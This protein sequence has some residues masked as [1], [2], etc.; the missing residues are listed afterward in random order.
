VSVRVE[1]VGAPGG[2]ADRVPDAPPG[3]ATAMP[4]LGAALRFRL[5]P[6]MLILIAASVL[7]VSGYVVNA[8]DRA[9]APELSKRALLIGSI[10]RAELQRTLDLGGRLD[11]IGGLERYLSDTLSKF[12]EVDAIVI[13]DIQGATVAAARRQSDAPVDLPVGAFATQAFVDR[14][15]QVMPILDGNRLVG[16]IEVDTSPTFVRTRLREVFLD[17]MV[18]ALATA[19]IGV[20]LTLLLVA[21]S[22]A[23]PLQ[24]VVYLLQAQR[25]GDFSHR[26]RRAGIGAL[27]RAAD[28]LNDHAEDLAERWSALSEPSRARLAKTVD[29]R[30]TSGRPPLLR[31]SN[32]SDI[33]VP[34][35]IYV[36]ATEVAVAFLP[37]Y[38][39]SLA[40]PAWLTADFAAA[41]PLMCYICT[42][43]LT[44]LFAG[45][46]CKR[47][48][49]RVVFL[50]SIPP[51]IAALVGLAAATH[52]GEVAFWR[53][54]M[55]AF[56]TT[57]TVACQQFASRTAGQGGMAQSLGVFLTVIYGGVFC[58]AALGGV[59]GGRFGFVAALLGGAAVAAL[60]GAAGA[61]LMR[62]PGGDPV[63]AVSGQSAPPRWRPNAR[64]IALIL[65][66]AV[67]MSASTSVFVW[68]LTPLLLTSRG[69][70]PSEVARVVMLYY[71]FAV[72]L[73]P[74][75]TAATEG[76]AGPRL[77]LAV[78]AGMAGLSLLSLSIWEG[79]W[80]VTVVMVA[81]GIGHTVMRTPLYVYA[82][83]LDPSA[84]LLL[85]L[86]MSERAGAILGL[87]ASAIA[88]PVLGAQVGILALGLLTLVGLTVHGLVE[89]T[90]RGMTQ[91]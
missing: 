61:A 60:A 74:V 81:L 43:A 20:E 24:R 10:V 12:A 68:Y 52:V 57:A 33:R 28:R 63:P 70:S 84:A 48:G 26:I 13:R 35:F 5:L 25:H 64:S 85:P 66:L 8:F 50:G 86:R 47:F 31:L 9:V 11:A 29:V 55:A 77:L 87:V 67:P 22:V 62:G 79:F 18:I 71:P 6:L 75:V 3:A 88:L 37:I 83:R 15:V 46:L 76:S 90:S 21:V 14:S 78:G 56:Y 36:I 41:L 51:T 39:R 80:A 17:V 54:A 30:I 91:I 7:A 40:R 72:L 34:L 32:V 42:A 73:G 82:Q 49:A 53:G 65:G 19:L 23:R 16:E 38:S 58:G 45:A 2:A 1:E 69:S 59:V 4:F 44:M 27:G 89:A